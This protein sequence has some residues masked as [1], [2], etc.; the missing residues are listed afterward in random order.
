MLRRKFEDAEIENV[1]KCLLD[2]C[3]VLKRSFIMWTE[4]RWTVYIKLDNRLKGL[5]AL[6]SINEPVFV[7][8]IS[9][10]LGKK[11]DPKEQLYH[12]SQ[13]NILEVFTNILLPN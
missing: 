10:S 6:F 8:L 13:P 9:A 12:E 1:G 4:I 7:F 2:R 5:G 3:R 11:K